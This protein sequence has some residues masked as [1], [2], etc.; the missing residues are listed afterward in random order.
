MVKVIRLFASSNN[1]NCAE[2][3]SISFSLPLLRQWEMTWEMES[4]LPPTDDFISVCT[5]RQGGGLPIRRQHKYFY[6]ASGNAG[7]N[8]IK[9]PRIVRVRKKNTT[10][11]A[12]LLRLWLFAFSSAFA[13]WIPIKSN[14]FGVHLH[15]SESSVSIFGFG[16]FQ[17]SM[18][19]ARIKKNYRCAGI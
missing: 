16:P 17:G 4:K 14:G 12:W 8:E 11:A 13:Y 7:G 6:V 9:F 1:V 19:L 18:F 5:R 10:N 15:V 2:H 3:C